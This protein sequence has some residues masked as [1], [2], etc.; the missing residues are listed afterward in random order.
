MGGMKFHVM[1]D[2]EPIYFVF[3][4]IGVKKHVYFLQMIVSANEFVVGIYKCRD[5]SSRYEVSQRRQ[6]LVGEVASKCTALI[7]IH[8]KMHM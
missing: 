2:R 7:V 1:L 5:T 8:T 6:K 4:L 3:I